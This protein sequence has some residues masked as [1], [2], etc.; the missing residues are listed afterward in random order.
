MIRMI[1]RKKYNAEEEKDTFR[2]MKGKK[3]LS[4]GKIVSAAAVLCLTMSLLAG[5]SC[6]AQQAVKEEAVYL[7]VKDYGM[8]ETNKDR[9]DEFLYRF[10]VDGEEKT[11]KLWNGTK[12]EDGNYDYP[13]QNVL[14]EGYPY[15][16]T[17]E[18]GTV[19]AA[20]EN[21]DKEPEIEYTPVVQG[22]PG[23]RTLTN[24][25]RT[26]LMPEGT[27]LY[28]YG[29]GWDW[30]DEGSAIQ[31]RT[32]GVSSDWIR[33]FD[34]QDENYTFKEIDGD[35]KNTD[36]VHSYY[37]YGGYNE[38]YYAGLDCSGYAGWTL[39]NTFE[40]E[41]GG[42]GKV[43]GSTKLAKRLSEQGLGDWTQDIEIPD[44]LNGYEMK[45]GDIMSIN[46][47]VW[48]SLGTCED[49]SV[50]IT[51]SSPSLSRSGQPGGGVQISAIGTDESCE[52][53]G[54][55]EWYMS[56][57]YPEWYERYPIYLCDPETY[58]TFEGEDA[59]RFTW[60]T[61]GSDQGLAD[62]DGLQEKTPEE[63]L[64]LLFDEEPTV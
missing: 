25:L 33:F 47:H 12:D 46:G 60:D 42:E 8:E 43:G 50:V 17:V 39:Y 57:Y 63:V 64:R 61:E 30:Q 22:V 36:P 49:G 26:A 29:G 18:G 6:G 56:E 54:L 13:V 9:K 10:E 24:F 1:I 40:T 55:A 38:Y 2:F 35:E 21:K 52:A 45:P 15:T 32:F 16:L 23:E 4:S 34:E 48:I 5:C 53:Y 62:P 44:G 41:S 27:T 59:G 58:F 14:K 7:G 11:Y 51:H 3:M 19:T 20:E 28:I 31:T 37:P